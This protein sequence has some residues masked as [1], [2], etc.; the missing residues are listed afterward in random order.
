MVLRIPIW[1]LRAPS[2]KCSDKGIET[3]VLVGITRYTGF[4]LPFLAIPKRVVV[5]GLRR[6]MDYFAVAARVAGRVDPRNY[7][8]DASDYDPIARANWW[9][10]G[11]PAILLRVKI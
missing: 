5:G 2:L 1:L 7:A 8:V 11:H 4:K 10:F 6:V 3:F 9:A